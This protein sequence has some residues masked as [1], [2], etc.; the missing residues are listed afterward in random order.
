MRNLLSL[1]FFL[2]TITQAQN[3]E[4]NFKE[5]PAYPASYSAGNVV[6][7]IIDGLGYRYY[8]ATDGLRSED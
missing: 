6:V 3:M 8:W 4:L 5:I 2:T 7:R 1:V